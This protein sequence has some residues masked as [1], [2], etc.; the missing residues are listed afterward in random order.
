MDYDF[1][2]I[3]GDLRQQYIEKLLVQK[4]YCVVTY[5]W[6][7]VRSA[8]S[9]QEAMRSP[10]VI[11]GIPFTRDQL[12]ICA[13][14]AEEDLT[15]ES[16]KAYLTPGQRF[17]AG[18]IP[19]SFWEYCRNSQVSVYDFM[20]NESLTLFNTIATA[21]GAIAEALLHQP[22]NLHR[23]RCLILGY[24][25]CAKVMAKKIRGM[26]A[27]VTICARS[28]E[29]RTLADAFGYDTLAFLNWKEHLNEFEYIFNTVPSVILKEDSLKKMRKDA[30]I[31]DIASKP[32]GIDY[33]AA[34][35]LGIQAVSA[36]GLPGKY[37]PKSTAEALVRCVL[38]QEFVS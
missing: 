15:L 33:D 12:T 35:R 26:E 7:G 5:G 17:Y 3:G 18:C 6:G 4:G 28:E 10:I 34:M 20:E 9:L 21:E 24:G 1:A 27:N 30:I 22:T 32:G 8:V 36:L 38:Q 25:K 37:A 31:I 19:K 23:S 13:M 16:M 2:V 11:S 29:D 14:K